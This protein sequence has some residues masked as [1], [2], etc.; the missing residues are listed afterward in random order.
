MRVCGA[1][2]GER[3]GRKS[4]QARGDHGRIGY[5][6]N[7][8]GTLISHSAVGSSIA[9]HNYRYDASARRAEVNLMLK[10]HHTLPIPLDEQD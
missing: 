6:S 4:W 8:A 9:H 2:P 3:K 5:A 10:R 1:R 7:F